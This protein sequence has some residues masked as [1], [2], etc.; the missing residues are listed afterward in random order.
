VAAPG[1]VASAAMVRDTLALPALLTT[2]AERAKITLQRYVTLFALL[3][4][5]MKIDFVLPK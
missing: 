3:F 4:S 5:F 1:G 2:T